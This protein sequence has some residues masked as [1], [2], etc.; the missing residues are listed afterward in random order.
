VTESQAHV[1]GYEEAADVEE[2]AKF[3]GVG[4]LDDALVTGVA[5]LELHE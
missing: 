4:A 3:R 5:G 1:I 2:L